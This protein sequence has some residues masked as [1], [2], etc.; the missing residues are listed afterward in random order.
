MI[1]QPGYPHRLGRLRHLVVGPVALRPPITRGLPLSSVDELKQIFYLFSE[2]D[3]EKRTVAEIV[4]QDS[5]L[6]RIV[7]S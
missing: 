3:K 6:R 2:Y 4:V 1:R 7:S 5:A